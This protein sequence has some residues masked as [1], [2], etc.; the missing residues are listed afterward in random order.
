MKQ[1]PVPGLKDRPGRWPAPFLELVA[2]RSADAPSAGAGGP[3]LPGLQVLVL[4]ETAGGTR[5]HKQ[6][7]A[8]AAVR[9]AAATGA[10]QV[11]VGSCGNYGWAVA[12]AARTAGVEATVVVPAGF[13]VDLGRMAAAGAT[14]LRMGATYEDAVAASRW[15]AGL[16]D[17]ADVNVDGPYARE[18]LAAHR[19]I[20]EQVAELP[21]PPPE[22]IWVPLG[23]GTTV[24]AVG[25]GILFRGWPTAV[26]GVSSAG[27]NSVVAAWPTGRHKPIPAASLR[28]TV[29]NEPLV[30]V[31]ALHGQEALV[32][33]RTTGGAAVGVADPALL[34]AQELLRRHGLRVSPAGAA[35]VAGLLQE[36]VRG[37]VRRGR[38]V[39]VLTA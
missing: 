20:V 24:T 37:A 2:A 18:V 8:E 4:D 12:R 36:A 9:A 1:A 11:V 13:A 16:L 25:G 26:M 21:G 32:A 17:A 15:L 28:P 5:C 14:V 3:L 35:G 22:A 39:A 27:N 23:N 31:E 30:N 6:P 38:H 10:E 19:M 29:A 7:A 33:L 34:A